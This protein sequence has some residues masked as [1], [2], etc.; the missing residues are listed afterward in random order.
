[1]FVIEGAHLTLDHTVVSGNGDGGIAT[2]PGSTLT[3]DHSLIA[4]NGGSGVNGAGTL[5]M[6]NSTVSDNLGEYGAGI[7]WRNGTVTMT[8]VTVT[9]NQGGVGGGMTI[10][11]A[12]MT[13]ITNCTF[14][15]NT[16]ATG[17]PRGT[18]GLFIEQGV[19]NVE[20]Q[21]TIIA[22]NT[23]FSPDIGGAV[24]SYGNNLIGDTTGGTGF[25][26]SDRLGVDPLLGTLADNGGAT[27]THALLAGSPAI[28]AGNPVGCPAL[29]QR[30][31]DRS[32][33]G[34]DIGAF[35]FISPGVAFGPSV[36]VLS[37]L[38]AIPAAIAPAG[39]PSGVGFPFGLFSWTLTQLP[40]GS[41]VTMDERST[42]TGQRRW[43]QRPHPHY[44]GWRLWGC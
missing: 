26:A 4:A 32:G 3:I 31:I 43:R 28:G 40:P 38:A 17:T 7:S 34:C 12:S 9:G 14:T 39:A 10:N 35:A 1:V 6:S 20:L 30:G 11:S 8:N 15:G 18:G 22:D 13:S 25:V 2:M 29:D 24:V 21:N 19:E 41:S 37:N 42:L 27:P 16:G 36:G 5:T 23:G 44:R 33:T